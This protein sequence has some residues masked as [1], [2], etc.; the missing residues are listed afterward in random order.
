MCA[1][2]RAAAAVDPPQAGAGRW[3]SGCH[4][5]HCT[6]IIDAV[7]VAPPPAHPCAPRLEGP[8]GPGGTVPASL[9]DARGMTMQTLPHVHGVDGAFAARL[10]RMR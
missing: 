5:S 7:P 6:D 9:L 10:R 4:D 1:S 3:N 8:R 2:M